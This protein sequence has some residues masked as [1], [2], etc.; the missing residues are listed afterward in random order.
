[1]EAAFSFAWVTARIKY[2]DVGTRVGALQALQEFP[3]IEP[4]LMQV[5]LHFDLRIGR[6]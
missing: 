6:D 4:F 1:M 3:R 5:F 2:N